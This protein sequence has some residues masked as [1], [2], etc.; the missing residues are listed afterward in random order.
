MRAFTRSALAPLAITAL[1]ALSGSLQAQEAPQPKTGFQFLVPSGMVI[2]TGAQRGALKRANLTAAQLSYAVRPAIAF[3]ATFGWARSRDVASADEPKL[4]VFT[5]DA[6]VELRGPQA[7]LGNGLTLMPFAGAGAGGRSYNYRDL[8]VDAT[9]NAAAYGSVGAEL[10]FHRVGL[11]LE[12]RDYV[13][14]FKPLVGGG[15]TARR[16]DVTV[17]AGVRIAF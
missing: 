14:G 13:T 10:G 12:G 4:D 2:P 7:P 17:L 3:T 11:R 15:S 6:G 16:N 5:Y 9:Q 8:D 1:L